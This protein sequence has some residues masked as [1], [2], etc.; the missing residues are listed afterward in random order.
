MQTDFEAIRR[1]LD[2]L[3]IFVIGLE[4]TN[5]LNLHTRAPQID[6]MARKIKKRREARALPQLK[7]GDKV[8][9]GNVNANI[10]FT[11]AP[12]GT[13]WKPDDAFVRRPLY[14]GEA[15]RVEGNTGNWRRTDAARPTLDTELVTVVEVLPAPLA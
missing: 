5:H 10:V 9:F 11:M 13:E 1:E 15:L 14:R 12:D 3:E 4:D 2:T 6:E 7:P 8:P